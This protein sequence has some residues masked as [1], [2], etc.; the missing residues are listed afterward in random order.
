[1]QNKILSTLLLIVTMA[2]CADSTAE[3]AI[4]SKLKTLMPEL[5][6]D[7]VS[8]SEI[9][10]LYA[11]ASGGTVLYVSDNGQYLVQGEIYDIQNKNAVVNLTAEKRKAGVKRLVSSLK[12][13]DLIIFPASNEKTYI[14]VFTDIDCGYC[15]ALQKE[16]PALNAAG[17]TVRYAAFPR[18]DKGTPSYQKAISVWCAKDRKAAYAAAMD[19]TDPTPANCIGNPVDR[20]KDMGE[21]LG[22]AGTPAIVF[23]NGLLIPGYLPE[24]EMIEAVYKNDK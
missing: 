13:A 23:K 9:P 11:V 18:S 21:D 4:S 10:G 12:P 22:I 14:T 3:T 15:H 16:V 7:S 20:E 19:G 24:K 6:I 8:P 1:M 2:A 5:T 17:I